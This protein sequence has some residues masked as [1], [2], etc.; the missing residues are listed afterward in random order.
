MSEEY[1]EVVDNSWGDRFGSSLFAVILGLILF[2]GS[3]ILLFWNEGRLNLSEIAK[4]A[5]EISA[6]QPN[7]KAIGKFISTTGTIKSNQAL[8]DNL[9]LIPGSY[10]VVDRTVEMFAW[11]EEKRTEERKSMLDGKVTKTTTYKYTKGWTNEPSDSSDFN[12]SQTHYNPKKAYSDQHYTASG[13][14]VGLYD[15]N[16]T[17]FKEVMQRKTSCDSNS[18]ALS[19]PTAEGIYL[20]SNSRL[21]LSA[22][23][24]KSSG[25]DVKLT[26]NYLFKGKGVPENP[27][28]GDVRICYNV[29][30]S[31]STVTVF[32]KLAPSNQITVYN[33]PKNTKFY[34]LFATSRN[35]AIKI[36]N[37]EYTVWTWVLRLIGFAAMSFGIIFA[38]QPINTLLKL[39]P[40]VGEWVEE[41]SLS[42]SFFIA[43]ILTM[44]TILVSQLLHHPLIL[45]VAIITTLIAFSGVKKIRKNY[46]N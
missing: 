44:V 19:Y 32:G 35:E 42:L 15:I 40:F 22:Q 14:K 33:A 29:I 10:S 6:T 39:I 21:Q 41:I 24:I 27:S 1:T 17:D 36:L 4:T 5:V 30:P 34:Q 46:L 18:T 7:Q 2:F 26:N 11:R 37:S 43:F 20:N 23:S 13:A 38:L 12:Y 31:N 8:G 16:M 28:I 3:F 45:I 25:D 9:F